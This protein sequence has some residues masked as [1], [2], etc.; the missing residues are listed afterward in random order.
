MFVLD[1]MPIEAFKKAYPKASLDAFPSSP[2]GG[3]V[4]KTEKTIR[5]AEYFYR[6]PVTKTLLE[7]PDGS[8]VDQDAALKKAEETGVPFDPKQAKRTR[9]V[10]TEEIWQCI[11]S[12]KEIIREPQRWVGKYIPL[13]PVLGEEVRL[14]GRTVRSGMVHDTIGPQQVLNY[15]VTAQ[16]EQAAKAPKAPIAVSTT[17]ISG[18]ENEWANAGSSNDAYLPYKSD[19]NAPGPPKRIDPVPINPGLTE[20]VVQSSQHIKDITGIYDA[21]LGAQSNETSGRA[22]LARQR[23]GDTGTYLY[24]DNLATAQRQ[25][26]LILIDIFPKVFDT[27]RIVRVLKEDGTHEMTPV[28][29]PF[30][31]GKKDALNNAIIKTHDLGVG[32]YDVVVSTGPGFATKRVEAA[33]TTQALIQAQPALMGVAGDLFIKSLD[34]PYAEEIAKRIE[35]TI[36]PNIKEDG[37]PTPPPPDPEKLANAMDKAASADLK[38]AQTAKTLL[39][40][41]QLAVQMSALG[42]Q[43]QGL[44]ELVQ[45]LAQGQQ[46]QPQPPQPP[47]PPPDAM[48]PGQPIPAPPGLPAAPPGDGGGEIVDL[49][50]IDQSQGAPA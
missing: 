13:V 6:K 49:E 32:E 19:P 18:Y 41:D 10:Q 22:I 27:P 12:G 30:D 48:P 2:S 4:W 11:M 20:L 7:L 43:L 16:V 45:S 31:T 38:H 35:R 33:N 39:E 5:V 36:P 14:D 37:P 47:M 9:K 24:I 15:A 23:E 3:M 40:A 1:D 44:T 34:I 8:V 25:I 26:G 42:I 28:N 50:P 29:Q 46:G 17:Q 21:S